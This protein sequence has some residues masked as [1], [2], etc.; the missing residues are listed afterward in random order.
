[1]RHLLIPGLTNVGVS[2]IPYTK[3]PNSISGIIRFSSNCPLQG[4]TL[5]FSFFFVVSYWVSFT[6]VCLKK[7]ICYMLYAHVFYVNQ[8]QSPF[9]HK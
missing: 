8:N 5:G 3:S 7:N 6:H 9:L 4:L 1:M 2:G